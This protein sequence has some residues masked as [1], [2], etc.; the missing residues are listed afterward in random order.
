M[1]RRDAEP[2]AAAGLPADLTTIV[3]QIRAFL[4]PP[5]T[6]LAAGKDFAMNWAPGGHWR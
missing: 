6:A 1:K 5:L 3:Q 4:E 2:A